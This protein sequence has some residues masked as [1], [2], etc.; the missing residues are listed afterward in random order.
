[1]KEPLMVPQKSGTGEGKVRLLH[2]QSELSKTIFEFE[3]F[4]K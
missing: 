2:Q 4:K 1:M 3:L